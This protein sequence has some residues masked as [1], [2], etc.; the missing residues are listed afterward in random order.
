MA[1]M[2]DGYVG[3]AAD[4][5]RI[6]RL[7]KQREDERVQMEEAKKKSSQGLMGLLQFGQGTSEVMESAFKKQ[8]IGLVTREEFVEKR[9]TLQSTLEEEERLKLQLMREE[10]EK[11]KLEKRLKRR[12][13]G[14]KNKLSFIDE[15]EDEEEEE[16]EENVEE[17]REG[18]QEGSKSGR[19]EVMSPGVKKDDEGT[20]K[21]N[22]GLLGKSGQQKKRKLSK[23][24]KDPTVETSFLPDREREAEE[25]EERARLAQ[26]WTAQ[27]ERI[28][29][30]PLEIT[31]SYWDGAGHRRVI[32]V[33]KGDTISDFLRS[34]QQQLGSEFREVRSTA[35]ENLIYIK[36]DVILPHQYTFYELIVNQARGKSGPLFHFDVHEDIRTSAN[37]NIEKDE[38]HAGKVVERHWYDKNKHIFPASRWEIYDPAKTWDRY[39]IHGT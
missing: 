10:E 18:K 31:Y 14:I 38:S 16:E 11:Q 19:E 23:F 13:V 33:R 28:K 39:T 15:F 22:D 32:Q 29:N 37:A 24:G 6:R 20:E 27:Q 5:V 36:E 4:W 25:A 2:G 34:V 3:S 17:E 30:E 9:A 1:G 26:L 12:A 35:V 21:G 8:T 7:E